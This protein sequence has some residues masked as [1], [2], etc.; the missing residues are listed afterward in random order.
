MPRD[1][2]P[3]NV[4]YPLDDTTLMRYDQVKFCEAR[5]ELVGILERAGKGHVEVCSPLFGVFDPD[6]NET[7]N[8]LGVFMVNSFRDVVGNFMGAIT[9]V[10]ERRER[11]LME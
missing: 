7:C 11:S 9:E 4:T 10:G 8:E 1:C 5:A 3:E 2:Y 6:I